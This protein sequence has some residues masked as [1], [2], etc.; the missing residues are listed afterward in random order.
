VELLDGRVAEASRSLGVAT[1]NIAELTAIGMAVEILDEEGVPNDAVVAL[2][3]DS[4]YAIGV[5]T[6]GWKAK[7]NRELILGLRDLLAKWPGVRLIWVK[8]H[9]GHDGNERAD[10]LARVG[11]TGVDRLSWST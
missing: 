11:A 5:L 8:G 10:E 7:A 2:H 6:L 1:N 9:A 4:K 3:T